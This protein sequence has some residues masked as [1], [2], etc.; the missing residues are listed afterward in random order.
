M[1]VPSFTFVATANAVLY[2]GGRPVF[3][4][5]FGL[6]NPSIDPAEVERLITRRTRAVTAV[7]FAGYPAAVD[8]LAELCRDR[9]LA[10]IEDAAHAPS[11]H[12][13]GRKLG[14]FGLASAFS[15]FSN[16]VLPVGEGGLRCW[17]PMTTNS[18]PAYA[19]ALTRH[20]EHDVGSASRSRRQL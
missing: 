4:D 8:Q 12:L 11:A 2:C 7:H 17:Q 3:A 19:A 5:I 13:G 18:R 10:L 20:D 16:K 9:G 6:E 14:T 1:I 15:F